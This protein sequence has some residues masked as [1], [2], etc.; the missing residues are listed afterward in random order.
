MFVQKL[1]IVLLLLLDILI[2]SVSG[3]DEENHI[4]TDDLTFISH[5][6]KI[7]VSAMRQYESISGN[8]LFC[9]YLN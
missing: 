5:W 2:N 6:M 1:L 4:Q 7:S 9:V 8:I 3:S